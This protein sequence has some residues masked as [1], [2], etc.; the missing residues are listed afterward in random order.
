M[1]TELQKHT[2]ISPEQ[3]EKLLGE[4]KAF[5]VAFSLKYGKKGQING[6][7]LKEISGSKHSEIEKLY[8]AYT[9]GFNLGK[10]QKD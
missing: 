1:K 7:L 2:K 6:R 3:E 9:L 4:L 8:I 5:V 10:S